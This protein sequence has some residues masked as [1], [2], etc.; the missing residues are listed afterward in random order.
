MTNYES[1]EELEPVVVFL[2]AVFAAVL[3]V[4]I[5]LLAT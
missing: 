5:V 2:G 1:H 4:M 3:I